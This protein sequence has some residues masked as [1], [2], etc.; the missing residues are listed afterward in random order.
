M[1][2]K[3]KAKK[4]SGE[5]VE[6][7]LEADNSKLVINQLQKMQV[8]PISVQE[9]GGGGGLQSEVSLQFL[10]RVT[11]KDVATFSRQLSDLIRA[12]LP[13]VKAMQ[14]ISK[15]T[16]NPKLIGILR[17]ITSD[18]EGGI[19]FSD[20]LAKHSKVFPPLYSSMVKAG[21]AGGMLDQVM[22][23]LADFQEAEQETRSRI[24]SAMTY[25]AF[26]IMVCFFVIIIL[27]TVVVPNF[28][29]MFEESD[30][31][32]PL[33]TQL[34]LNFTNF[35]SDYWW[36]MLGGLI[37]GMVL[38]YQYL[39]TETGA[40]QFDIMK[41]KLPL[42][43]DL[44]RK[45]EI[46]K[47]SRTLGTLLANGVQIL[48]ALAI[49]ENVISNQVLKKD[50]ESFAE[51]IKEGEKLSKRMEQSDLFPP[52]AVNMVA[53]GEETG[54]LEHTLERVADS[55]ERET[56]RV[57]KTITT[58]IEP[59]MIVVMAVVV[60]FIVFAMIMPIFQISQSIN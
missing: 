21:E 10:N 48:K 17:D 5:V 32:L 31:S 3:Y 20:A 46:A 26:M 12:G 24:V 54:N 47:F 50:I 4:L 33:S 41:L 59:V 60:G 38:F 30:V 14:V 58:I 22:E 1:Q 44:I 18:I 27:F 13:L 6:G 57:I 51:N 9:V 15:Q 45:R 28:M 52:I 23:R 37:F 11:S 42:I 25:P 55:F 7:V 29:K 34:L 16:G 39:K 36:L 40:L 43:G 49:T 2:F 56:E 8:F 19:S 35:I 53:V